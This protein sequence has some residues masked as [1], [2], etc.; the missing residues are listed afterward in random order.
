MLVSSF[1]EALEL[2]E[3]KSLRK[4]KSDNVVRLLR[5]FRENSKLYMVFELLDHSLL[6]SMREKGS[7]FSEPEI[8]YIMKQ[9]L[10][11]INAVHKQGFFHRDIKPDNLIWSHDGILKV[12]DF[13]LAREIRSRP[14]YTDYLGTRWYRAPE[15][16]LRHESYNSP[17]DIWAMGAIMAELYTMKPL[18]Q[19]ERGLDQLFKIFTILGT[20]TQ[21]NWP[22]SSR[23]AGK[24]NIKFPQ[25][26]PENLETI[27]PNASEDGLSLIKL[28]LTY[29]PLKRPSASQLL[30]HEFFQ[31]DIQPYKKN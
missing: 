26:P 31:G 29:D 17:V 16:L 8:R 23:L 3:V 30:Q 25:Y 22:D 24:M 15:L 14:P 13:G 5:L 27:I 28:M 21:K 12:A 20:P 11:G 1:Q 7:P 9:A 10:E 4:I 19:G 6:N 2:K 18:F